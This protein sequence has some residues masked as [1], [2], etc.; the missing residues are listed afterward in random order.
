MQHDATCGA[1][2]TPLPQSASSQLDAAAE[3]PLERLLAMQCSVPATG[4]ARIRTDGCS[5]ATCSSG[6]RPDGKG[7]CEKVML[8]GAEHNSQTLC[9]RTCRSCL[10]PQFEG[11][12]VKWFH[13]TLLC[14]VLAA[15]L[16]VCPKKC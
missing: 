8:G 9:C 11:L 1:C 10:G 12:R 16:R 6:F 3:V 4:C 15:Q 13:V 2:P 5:C 7:G 14:A